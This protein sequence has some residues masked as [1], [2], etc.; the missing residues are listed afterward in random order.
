MCRALE[1]VLAREPTRRGAPVIRALIRDPRLTRSERERLILKLID[2]A[3]LP[4][5]VTNVRTQGCLVD[6]LWPAQRLV[7][8]F[9]G[10]RAHGHRLAFE[11]DRKR[12]QLL[13]AAGYRVLRITDRQLIDESLVEIAR[14]AQALRV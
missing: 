14:V 9:D 11:N 7:L 13:V 4:R 8:E 2:D 12:D 5:P 6:V 1:A 10:W 3:Q